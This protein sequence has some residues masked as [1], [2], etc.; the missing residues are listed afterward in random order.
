MIPNHVRVQ[1]TRRI[2]GKAQ[3]RCNLF[4]SAR[5]AGDESLQELLP[6]L[7]GAESPDHPP[8]LSSGIPWHDQCYDHPPGMNPIHS[9]A[10]LRASIFKPKIWFMGSYVK[11]YVCPLSTLKLIQKYW[12]P[13]STG[14]Q[15]RGRFSAGNVPLITDDR[16]YV[17]WKT[18]T[19]TTFMVCW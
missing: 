4:C 6:D 5:Q 1:P 19:K 8:G 3:W 12:S 11:K 13:S 14:C 16:G 18:I 17:K 15:C 9:L 10:F 7:I 2:P